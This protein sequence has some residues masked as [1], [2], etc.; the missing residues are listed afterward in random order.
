MIPV[1]LA[2]GNHGAFLLCN[3][4][5]HLPSC[6]QQP[7]FTIRLFHHQDVIATLN[8]TCKIR[9]L[10]VITINNTYTLEMPRPA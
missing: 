7:L 9:L 10:W 6:F 4:P 5:I 8:F 3:L 2:I 1:H